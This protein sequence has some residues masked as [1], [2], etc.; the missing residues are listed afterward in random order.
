MKTKLL[1]ILL[2]S[3]S[4]LSLAQ[5]AINT[6][7]SNPNSS[8]ILDIKSD[9]AGILIPRMTAAQRDAINQPANGLMVYVNTDSSFYY[10]DGVQWKKLIAASDNWI[11][12]T[13]SIYSKP[14]YNIG[15]GTST[16]NSNA[17]LDVS[18][19]DKGLLVPRL[20]KKQKIVLTAALSSTDKGML[21]YDLD[22]LQL[23]VWD[24][25]AWVPATSYWRRANNIVYVTT[26]D[27]VGIGTSSPTSR[28]DVYGKIAISGTGESVFVGKDAGSDDD[29]IDGKNVGIGT[30]AL[31]LNT[32]ANGLVGIG[33]QALRNNGTAVGCANTSI[34]NTAIGYR[35]LYANDAGSGNT[36]V[37][38]STLLSNNT[39]SANTAVGRNSLL[40]NTTGN[41]NTAI[42]TYSL[43]QNLS[44]SN[45]IAIG[46]SS[47]ES[48]TGGN[49][50]IGIGFHALDSNQTGHDN[51]AIGDFCLSQNSSGMNN[52]GLGE[53][54]LWGNTQGGANI[55][56]GFSSL[57]SNTSGNFNI[58]LGDYSLGNNEGG[59][60]N[61]AFGYEALKMSNNYNS[62]I[63]IGHKTLYSATGNANIAI[64][65]NALTGTGGHSYLIAIGD[66]SLKNTGSYN[67]AIGSKSLGTSGTGSEN[68]AL[69]HASLRLNQ[70]GSSNIGIGH[71]ALYSNYGG[72][73]NTGL[74]HQSLYSNA[75]G[76][77]NVA[78]GYKAGYSTIHSGNVFIGYKAGYNETGGNKL[79]IANSSTSSPLIGGDFSTSQVDINGTIKITGGNPGS[80][81]VLTSDANGLAS[82]ETLSKNIN[83][84]TDG[85]ND[86]YS[87]FLGTNSGTNDD[88]SLN[89]NTGL[90]NGA[91]SQ[92]TS[93]DKN[94]TVGNGASYYNTTG[95]SNTSFGYNSLANNSTG[96]QNTAIGTEAG[97]SITGSGNVLLGYRAG[98]NETGSNKLYI[99]N[100]STSLPL[101]GGD[102]STSQVNINGT[103]KITGGSPAAG[104][105]LTSDANGLAS[106]QVV[107]SATGSIDTH[108]DVD[109]T[110]TAPTNGQFL[111]WDGSNWVPANDNNTTYSAGTGLS[112]S[113]TIFSLNSGIDNLTDVDVS[114]NTPTIG[115]VLNWDGTNWTP[116]NAGATKIDELLDAI[117]DSSS[118]F[119]G[120]YSGIADDGTNNLNSALGSSAL[121]SNTSGAENVAIGAS[122]LYN[123]IS[124]NNNTAIGRGAGLHS[125]GSGNVF[126]GYR[127]GTSETGSNKLY[128]ANSATNSPLI[129]GDF[130]SQQLL[131]NGALRITGTLR[132]DG[133]NPGAN[134]VLTSDAFGNA[135]WQ[136]SSTANI[137]INDLTD[138]STSGNS[139][140]LGNS[141]GNNNTT[142]N[143]N[144]GVGYYALY[145][146]TT[147][148][149]NSAFGEASL[150][151]KSSGSNNTALGY[152]AAAFSSNGSQ[153][154]N[155]GS[156]V[157]I[158]FMT[159][160]ANPSNDTNEVVIGSYAIGL[161]SNTVNLGNDSIKTTAL[162]GDVGIGTTSPK[163]KLQVDGGIQMAN[164][165][166]TASADK[167]GTLR[168]RADSNHSYVE[169]CVQ[170]GATTY[171]WVVIH[172]ETW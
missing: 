149:C 137:A 12:T 47:M 102:F 168:Y 143:G 70:F 17:I 104:K 29:F 20:T 78:I 59:E 119:L 108:S 158:G 141:A 117:N 57:S 112:L 81:K 99:A 155:L 26:N 113:G 145:F 15:V 7:G 23:Y 146:N 62:N 125:T 50:N 169:M 44:G 105:V 71:E 73:L 42:G 136:P 147:D 5:V 130:S 115:Q 110:T 25:S 161:G 121:R 170:T 93:G 152:G 18:S 157:F 86:G 49:N 74:G 54:A 34:N 131:V 64:G 55:A 171:A 51:I 101:I 129:Y 97:K 37:G 38:H 142:G 106:W 138:G 94:T 16:P 85:I 60:Y 159:K 107:T 8:A 87:V 90:G 79:Y 36:A 3:I 166:A 103:I 63:A 72:E 27:S 35:S 88:H 61:I 114:S 167:V 28:L 95:S 77:S 40:S 128:I 80:G 83:G 11:K 68:M 144:T 43:S 21:I 84:L 45:N 41:S 2:M 116:T 124:G 165:T 92:N 22:Q 140:F 96:S 120:T 89:Y 9:T 82:W 30:G 135:S 53:Y 76:D 160:A 19:K 58:A 39:G 150:I 118:I 134:K 126:V 66:S 48:S 151:F 163:S 91:L 13:S 32:Q 133:G 153:L 33:Y 75:N 132:I 65:D 24:G 123:N 172:Q 67:L 56:L 52:I 139:V 6:D 98:Y 14:S 164:D 46:I 148:S 109:V 127:A 111:S 31:Q 10:Y 1:F 156:S 122:A 154:T 4:A 69:G 100:S 162:H